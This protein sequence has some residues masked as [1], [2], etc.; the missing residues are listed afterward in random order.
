MIRPV[1]AIIL[2]AMLIGLLIVGCGTP[3]IEK[4]NREELFT[5]T[6]G[7]MENQIDLF[8]VPGVPFNRKNLI[9]MKGGRVYISNG[10]SSKIMEFTSYGDLLFLLQSSESNPTP[11]MLAEE[12]NEQ[13]VTNRSARSFPFQNI[14]AVVVESAKN[15]FVEDEVPLEQREVDEQYGVLYYKR[16]LRFD[17][18]GRYIDFLGQEGVGGSPFPFIESVHITAQD[19]LVVVSRLAA[20]WVVFWFDRDGYLIYRVEV[21]AEYLPPHKGY[22]PTVATILPDL[23]SPSLFLMVT[24]YEEEINESTKTLDA[25]DKALSRIYRFSLEQ[26]K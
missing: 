26:E 10:N 25:S 9:Y 17:R 1:T 15:L 21:D 7:K 18:N 6:L 23:S 20:R 2:C 13:D 22:I 5:L 11:F 16:V 8:Q 4:L 14:G 24:Y 19:N 12:S 3:S